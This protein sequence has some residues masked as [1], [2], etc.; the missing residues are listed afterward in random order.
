M[1]LASPAA[2]DV[3]AAPAPYMQ[4]SASQVVA[5]VSSC[6]SSAS[7]VKNDAKYNGGDDHMISEV[8]MGSNGKNAVGNG[9]ALPRKA[10]AGSATALLS[11]SSASSA[12]AS[13]FGI[14]TFE[15]AAAAAGAAVVAA[16]GVLDG[17]G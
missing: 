3:Q 7:S 2:S 15:A 11:V 10:P 13:A 4:S 6:V 1:L 9:V 16:V 14:A 5:S 17:V 8:D 12:T